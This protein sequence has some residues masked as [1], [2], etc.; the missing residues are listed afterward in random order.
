MSKFLSKYVTKSNGATLDTGLGHLSL[1]EI[2]EGLAEA[3]TEIDLTV[4]DA[5][6]A[7]EIAEV[8]EQ[9]NEAIRQHIKEGGEI[10]PFDA[11][12]I[13]SSRRIAAA[14]LG[15]DDEVTEEIV[16]EAGLEAMVANVGVVSL[17][18]SEGWVA[19]ISAGARKAYD[20]V[21]NLLKKFYKFMYET[22]MRR[23]QDATKKLVALKEVLEKTPNLGN[24]IPAVKIL[25]SSAV[26]AFDS[27]GKLVDLESLFKDTVEAAESVYTSA[28]AA[29]KA[30]SQTTVAGTFS[31]FAHKYNGK[32]IGYRTYT[33]G[34]TDVTKFTFEASESKSK[35]TKFDLKDFVNKWESMAKGGVKRH[36]DAVGK[37]IKNIEDL[38]KKFEEKSKELANDKEQGASIK[39][40]QGLVSG[41]LQLAHFGKSLAETYINTFNGYQQLATLITAYGKEEE[42]KESK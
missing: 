32:S 17:E 37:F 26:R 27:S 1:E 21:L 20:W 3:S 34:V 8:V 7:E 19:K 18:E 15:G 5:S 40:Q 33:V 6:R 22:I 11:A 35:I 23:N 4:G 39:E 12:L 42:K 25:E 9:Q 14:A 13:E 38:G 31:E 16:D 36:G 30:K 28:K 24:E 2:Q 10:T 29:L 41:A